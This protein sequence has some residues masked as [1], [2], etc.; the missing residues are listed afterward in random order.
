MSV[1]YASN[2]ERIL[3][4][5]RVDANGCFLWQKRTDRYGYL[6]L[7][8]KTI[9]AHRFSYEVF[10]GPVPKG[11]SVLHRCDVPSCCNPAHL[12]LGTQL[13]N[14]RDCSAKKRIRTGNRQGE[15]G[16]GR[17]TN[18]IIREIRSLVG[19]MPQRRIAEKFGISYQHC[20][21]IIKR[22]RWPHI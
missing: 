12:F 19:T 6:R 20:S 10:R 9:K 22:K 8:G 7:G 17:L 14:M 5:I 13:E 18:D 16:P 15:N 3:K 1:R 2:E 21:D 11:M 4:N